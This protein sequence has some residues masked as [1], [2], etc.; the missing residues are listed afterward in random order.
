MTTTAARDHEQGCRVC[1]QGTWVTH[2]LYWPLL[3]ALK[4]SPPFIA[5]AP[6]TTRR[7]LTAWTCVVMRT[8][9]PKRKSI[10][11]ILKILD[12]LDVVHSVATHIDG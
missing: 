7:F 3:L 6:R 11:D 5:I 9:I 10:I 1:A 2:L 8:F 4:V 12:K